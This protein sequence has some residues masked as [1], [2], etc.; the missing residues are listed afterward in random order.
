M[1]GICPVCCAK[2]MQTGFPCKTLC[3]VIRHHA[4]IVQTVD[5]HCLMLLGRTVCGNVASCA[6]SP[7]TSSHI[8]TQLTVLLLKTCLQILNVNLQE[9]FPGALLTIRAPVDQGA[10]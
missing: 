9:T 3:D 4:A 5:V 1:D 6:A 10:Q 8:Y 2:A 7:G